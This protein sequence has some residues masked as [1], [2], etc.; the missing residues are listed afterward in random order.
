MTEQKDDRLP[1]QKPQ[2]VLDH[3]KLKDPEPSTKPPAPTCGQE[4][5]ISERDK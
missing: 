1:H 3:S 5:Q 2:P 4:V